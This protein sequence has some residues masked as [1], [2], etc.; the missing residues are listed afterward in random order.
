MSR[1]KK[2]HNAIIPK[3]LGEGEMVAFPGS[4]TRYVFQKNG[5][6]VNPDRKK[7]TKSQKRILKRARIADRIAAQ[8]NQSEC[9]QNPSNIVP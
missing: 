2:L 6:V 1:E 3:K 7:F 5:S 9:N 4:G 8:K